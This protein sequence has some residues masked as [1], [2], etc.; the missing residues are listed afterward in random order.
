MGKRIEEEGLKQ[1]IKRHELA[2]SS[3]IAGIKAL[4]QMATYGLAP[5]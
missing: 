3:T 4:V 5:A 1:V 2:A